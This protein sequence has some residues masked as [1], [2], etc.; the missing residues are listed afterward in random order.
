MI[1]KAECVN[2]GDLP[3][4]KRRCSCAERPK[5]RRAGVRVPIVAMKPR[6]G[7]GAKGAQEGGGVSDQTTENKPKT[8]SEEAKQIGEAEAER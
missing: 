2:Q 8:V 7:G 1:G 6:N 3:V 5:S 4:V